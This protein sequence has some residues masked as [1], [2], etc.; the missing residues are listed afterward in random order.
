MNK[1]STA[2]STKI[3]NEPISSSLYA[4][5]FGKKKKFNSIC[6]N[7]TMMKKLC[8]LPLL[9]WCSLYGSDVSYDADIRLRG[10]YFN[11]M[12]EKY[13]GNAPA[14]GQSEDSYLLSRVRLGI[15]YKVDDSLLLRISGQ[16]SRAFGYEL[17]SDDWY[18]KEFNQ[19]NNPQE[20]Y[21]ELS[22]T[23]IKKN[24]SDIELKI[25]RQKMAFGDNRIFGPGEWKNSGKWVW[26]AAKVTYK[27]DEHFISLFYGA[28]MLHDEN[29]FSL[30]HRHGYY[31]Y[32]IYSHL[33][34]GTVN[35]EPMLFRKEND[36]ENSNYLKLQSN[37][38]GAR[39][40]GT[41]NALFFDTTVVKSFGTRTNKDGTDVDIDGLGLIAVA[42]YKFNNMFKA[43]VEYVRASG[44]NPNTKDKNENFDGAFGA[45]DKYYGRMNL[46]QFSNLIDYSAFADI[47]FSDAFRSKLEYHRF[48]ADR[49][50]NKWLSY[51]FGDMKSDHYGDEID[52]VSAY[53]HSKALSF[54]LGLSYFKS[55]SYIQ[56]ATNYSNKITDDNAFSVFAQVQYKFKG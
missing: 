2:T 14:A 5:R 56:E 54:Q 7:N 44:D 52:L 6:L 41:A 46:F 55:G 28:T 32:G 12:N 17:T 1:S 51:S 39:I 3:T 53:D 18:N 25:G 19:K 48:Y 11:N 15:T 29:H 21:F 31:G 50:T 20:D 49:P 34:F 43:G 13:Y 9:A 10:E 30:N 22:E 37:Y 47:K 33:N 27:T 38:A 45:S 23:Y 24:F 26:D 8:L 16:D 40:Y 36:K 4:C 42:G 35:V